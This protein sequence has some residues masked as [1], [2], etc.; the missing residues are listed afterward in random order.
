[1][2]LKGITLEQIE[3][4]AS[5][6]QKSGNTVLLGEIDTCLQK[7]GLPSTSPETLRV[8]TLRQRLREREFNSWCALPQKG[9]G[10]ILYKE[11][12]HPA[13]GNLIGLTAVTRGQIW[14]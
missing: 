3:F 2:T 13:Y 7:L 10:V 8:Q 14:K 1:M 5:V 6:C 11:H 4:R 9:K 12:T